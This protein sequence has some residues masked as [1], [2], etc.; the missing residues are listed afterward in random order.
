MIAD[1]QAIDFGLIIVLCNTWQVQ[2]KIA[3]VARKG[4]PT[5]VKGHQIAEFYCYFTSQGR[6]LLGYVKRYFKM[7]RIINFSTINYII[8]YNYSLNNHY[9]KT[10]YLV[11]VL[12]MAAAQLWTISAATCNSW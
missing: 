2:A 4:A 6:K 8:I 10:I 12:A 9:V 5:R 11:E 1:F 7:V 3:E